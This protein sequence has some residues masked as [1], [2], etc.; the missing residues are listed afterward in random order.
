MSISQTVPPKALIVSDCDSLTPDESRLSQRGTPTWELALNYPYQGEWTEEE[1]LSLDTNR[2]I[3]FTDGVLEFLPTPKPSHARISRFISDLLRAYVA[4]KSLGDVFWAPFSVR[5]GPKK[6]REPDIVYLSHGR[7]PREDLPPDGADLVVEVV[8]EG[9]QNRDRDLRTKR[10]EYA[11]A[12]IPEYWIV[13]PDSQA[14]TVLTLAGNTYAV[15]GEFRAGSQA[16]SVLLPGFQVDVQ[17][18]FASATPSGK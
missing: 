4:S 17:A 1:Y 18:V 13:D 5:I 11:L 6:L 2:L 7:I 14:I 9:G 8:S 12:G 15:H 16:T 10:G 3:E